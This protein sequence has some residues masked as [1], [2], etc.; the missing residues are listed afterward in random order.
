M[1]VE[2]ELKNSNEESKRLQAKLDSLFN[3][4]KILNQKVCLSDKESNEWKEKFD[5]QKEEIFSMNLTIAEA[6]VNYYYFF[7]IIK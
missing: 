6:N 4:L 1:F 2:N 3:E 5:K 7:F